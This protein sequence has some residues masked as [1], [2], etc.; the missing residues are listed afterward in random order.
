MECLNEDDCA[1]PVQQEC[2]ANACMQRPVWADSTIVYE[3]TTSRHLTKPWYNTNATYDAQDDY[4]GVTFGYG[5]TYWTL[6]INNDA[7]LGTQPLTIFPTSSAG[8]YATLIEQDA[9]LA[10]RLQGVYQIAGGTVTFT[11]LDVRHGG[12]VAGTIDAQLAGGNDSS[13]VPATLSGSFYGEF[14]P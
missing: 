7:T 9:S 2:S 3:S 1:N 11:Q 12:V 5:W 14:P 4:G 8:T 6:I 10:A 13:P